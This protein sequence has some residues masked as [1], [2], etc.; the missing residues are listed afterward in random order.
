MC[1]LWINSECFSSR[2]LIGSC[3]VP[4]YFSHVQFFATP[5]DC[6]PPGSTVHGILQGRILECIVIS[7]SRG[8]SRPRNQTHISFV[9]C[10]GG[11]VLYHQ[12]HLGSPIFGAVL[13]GINS[14][15]FQKQLITE[16]SLPTPLIHYNIFFD[17]NQSSAWLV[18]GKLNGSSL[19]RF[20]RQE[21][22]AGR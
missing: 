22:R 13:V 8:S 9:S 10:I 20:Q 2:H 6:S 1:L 19:F 15:I 17:E 7:Y 5:T 11:Q 14:L 3:I 4:N 21:S 12:H 16:E 18:I